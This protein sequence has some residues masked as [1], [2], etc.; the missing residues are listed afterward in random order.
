MSA[1]V[2]DEDRKGVRSSSLC[3]AYAENGETDG[4]TVSGSGTEPFLLTSRMRVYPD[5]DHPRSRTVAGSQDRRESEAI[6][7][8]QHE[9]GT[10]PGNAEP[11]EEPD[12]EA[13]TRHVEPSQESCEPHFPVDREVLRSVVAE[14]IREEFQGP[15]GERITDS[16]RRFV[17][18]ELQQALA[19]RDQE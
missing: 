11:G 7:N 5:E 10:E 13:K 14:L 4:S 6:R 17:N 8:F 12:G 9:A 19:N 3:S 18:R 2:K 15:M 16:I 1:N